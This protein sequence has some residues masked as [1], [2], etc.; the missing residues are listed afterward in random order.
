MYR[1]IECTKACP[2]I[3]SLDSDGSTAASFIMFWKNMDYNN[4]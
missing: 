4:F 3:E 2:T 1:G